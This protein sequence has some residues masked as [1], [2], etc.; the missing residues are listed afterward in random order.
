MKYLFIVLT[1]FVTF[2]LVEEKGGCPAGFIIPA[3]ETPVPA[4]QVSHCI[5]NIVIWRQ[6]KITCLTVLR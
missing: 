2:I 3:G 5:A 4:R 6:I 1:V